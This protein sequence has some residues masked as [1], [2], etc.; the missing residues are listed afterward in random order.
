MSLM[1]PDLQ[2][3]MLILVAWIV[4]IPVGVLLCIL[5]FRLIALLDTLHLLVD[6]IRMEITPLLNSL[7]ETA[8]HVEALTQKAQHSLESVERGAKAVPPLVSKGFQALGQRLM[9]TGE[10]MQA[11]TSPWLKTRGR[12]LVNSLWALTPWG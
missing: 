11:V 3:S 12:A 1:S 7:Q 4:L 2:L 6:A 8:S 9:T 5:L 10:H